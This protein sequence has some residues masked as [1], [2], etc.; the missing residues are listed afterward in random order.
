MNR[1]KCFI[2]NM[3]IATVFTELFLSVTGTKSLGQ[4]AEEN[5]PSPV[6]NQKVLNLLVIDKVTKEPVPDVSLSLRSYYQNSGEKRRQSKTDE[7]GKC[8]IEIG[9]TLPYVFRI[10]TSY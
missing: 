8:R 6:E 5:A 2:R 9:R 7:N 10:E 1:E 3:I 4:A